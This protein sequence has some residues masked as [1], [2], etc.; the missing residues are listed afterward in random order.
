M[1]PSR[2]SVDAE[3]LIRLDRLLARALERG[4]DAVQPD[5]DEDARMLQRLY[6]AARGELPGLDQSPI[7]HEAL[8]AGISIDLHREGHGPGTRIGPFELESPIGSGGMGTVYRARRVDGGFDQIVALKLLTLSPPDPALVQLF[9]RER[10]LLARLEH[11]GIARLIDGGL[12]EDWQ[13]WFAMEYIEGRPLHDYAD[14]HRLSFRRRIGLVIQACEAL[15]HAHRQL[16]LHRDIKPANLLVTGDERVHIV[17]FG[18]GRSLTPDTPSIEGAHQT[19]AAGRLTPQYASPEQARGDAVSV[20][21]DVYQLGLV[22]YRLL[23]GTLPYETAG[24]N[25]SELADTLAR[26]HIQPPSEC[27]RRSASEERARNAHELSASAMRRAVRG[28]LDNIV[29]MALDRDP[30][31]RYP[32]ASAMANDLRR[33]LELLPVRARAATRRYRLGRFVR[34]NAL[35]VSLSA[36]A[37]L[38]LVSGMVALAVQADRLQLERD[39]ALASAQRNERLAGALGGMI[40]LSSADGPVDQLFTAGERLEDYLSHV[41]ERLADDPVVRL[42][43]LEI[44]GDAFQGLQLWAQARNAFAEALGLGQL[45]PDTAPD[46][47]R[48]LVLRLATAT[49]F[50]GDLATAWE[51]LD[52]LV[53]SLRSGAAHR[54]DLAEALYQRGYLKTYHLPLGHPEYENGLADLE[55]A[56]VLYRELHEPTHPNTAATL[57][58]LGM[59]HPAP[60]RRLAL[61]QEAIDMTRQLYGDEHVTVAAR[62]AE[63]ALVL[64]SLGEYEQ[65]AATGREAYELHARLR[66]DTHPETLTILANLAGSLREAGQLEGAAEQYHALH[67]LRLRILPE[68]HLL[69]AFTAHGLG[70][71]YRALGRYEASEEWLREALR[72]CRLHGSSNEAITRV[73]LS[74]TLEAAGRLDEAIDQQRQALSAYGSF[75]P[76]GHATVERARVRLEEL[77]RQVRP[78]D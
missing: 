11:P 64:D 69:L 4:L 2:L 34:R 39:R 19:I 63:L 60:D 17:D 43:M 46:T 20:A 68:D 73:N 50:S 18:L 74:K 42:Q 61:V 32:S 45:L 52:R 77:D 24:L 47:R 14:S 28:D 49:A 7:R 65:A 44:L 10:Q 16:I 29:M 38:V 6:K 37:L 59:K 71:T 27:W 75:L 78:G 55:R 51:R 53:E 21:S 62:L 5:N 13:P 36:L 26:A 3:R 22:L 70:N 9:Q 15:D 56:L 72:L 57:H 48:R 30:R 41:R 23:T 40:R 54:R 8:A 1:P 67:D 58:T 35:A 33:H 12:T 66:G 25:A 31:F 76:E